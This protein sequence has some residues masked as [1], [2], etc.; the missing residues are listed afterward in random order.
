MRVVYDCYILDDQK[1]SI[2]VLCQALKPFSGLDICGHSSS[3]EEAAYQLCTLKPDLLFL[4]VEMPG[5]SGFDFLQ[6]MREHITW[7]MRV[8]VYT[9][10]ENYLLQALRSSAFDFLLKPFVNDELE[11]ILNRFFLD[12]PT[13]E[14]Y[15]R[16]LDQLNIQ[17]AMNKPF[18][19]PTTTGSRVLKPNE[20]IY[21]EY[22]KLLRYWHLYPSEGI[23]IKLRRET[24]ADHLL[25]SLPTF[26]RINPQQ[27]LN[28]GMLHHLEG[29]TC[30][31]NPPHDSLTN[32]IVSRDCLKSLKELFETI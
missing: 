30:H 1:S 25:A 4:D 6:R 18:M 21:F 22:N 11:S 23:P 8:V 3:V 29:H 32:L 16:Q 31:L 9:A 19:V 28:P 20:I 14:E 17:L 26:V 7:P 24:T 13:S 2:D 10:Y 27:I 15:N 12:P 5:T